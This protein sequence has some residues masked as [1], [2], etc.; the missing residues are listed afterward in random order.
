MTLLD[1]GYAPVGLN[2][3][4]LREARANVTITPR[5]T[6]GARRLPYEVFTKKRRLAADSHHR[7]EQTKF[8][9]SQMRL[10][11]AGQASVYALAEKRI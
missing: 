10:L 4:D 5:G 11:R 7:R 6:Y 8:V 1:A 9:C 3:D 2:E